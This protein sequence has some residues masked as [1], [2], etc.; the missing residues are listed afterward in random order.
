MAEISPIERSQFECSKGKPPT[1]HHAFPNLEKLTF[2]GLT[3]TLD[4]AVDL[5]QTEKL[6]VN[7]TETH[8]IIPKSYKHVD[9]E[10]DIQSDKVIAPL[11]VAIRNPLPTIV[12]PLRIPIREFHSIRPRAEIGTLLKVSPS[13]Q[14]QPIST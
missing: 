5:P 1:F 10:V 9:F 13:L 14:R 8:I 2:K 11:D 3:Y 6:E 12:K 7:T 4:D